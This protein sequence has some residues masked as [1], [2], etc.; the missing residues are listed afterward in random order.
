M[1][2]FRR[3]EETKDAKIKAFHDLNSFLEKH[4]HDVKMFER[5][6]NDGRDILQKLDDIIQGAGED[7]SFEDLEIWKVISHLKTFR[8]IVDLLFRLYKNNFTHH[9]WLRVKRT[10]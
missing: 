5:W 6:K 4:E 3:A 10:Y 1:E 8:L 9:M 7:A 2:Q